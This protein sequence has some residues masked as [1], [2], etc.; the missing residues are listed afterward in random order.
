MG[1][2]RTEIWVD[3]LT[4]IA[5]AAQV[6][7]KAMREINEETSGSFNDLEFSLGPVNITV[8]GEDNGWKI[9]H[10][11][12]VTWFVEEYPDEEESTETS[13]PFRGDQLIC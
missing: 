13:V 12:G 5:R 2:H 10:W 11:D 9:K 4:Q 8:D 7:D 1:R 6:Y 3:H